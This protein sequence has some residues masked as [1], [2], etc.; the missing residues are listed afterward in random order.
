MERVLT[1][2][3]VFGFGG[4]KKFTGK[5]VGILSNQASVDVSLRTT[6]QVVEECLPGSVAALFGPQHGYRGED[7]DNMVETCHAEEP[8]LGVPV[9]SLYSDTRVPL[10]HML[11]NMEL[12][13]V[14][15]QDV[16]TRVYTFAS[17]V[18]NCLRA[19]A[20]HG[21]RVVVLDRPNPVGGD[22]TE[23]NVLDPAYFSFVG[24]ACIPMRHGLTLGELALLLNDECG[25]GCG[26]EVVPMQG[27][28]RGMLWQE[29][30][31][32]WLLPSTN[33][34]CPDTAA[35]YP[36]QVVWEGTNV[37]EGRGTCRP[38]EI[39]GAPFLDVSA[40]RKALDPSA[41]RGCYLQDYLFR[42]TFH[43]W[44]GELCRGFMLHVTD[45]DLY[46]PYYTSLCLLQA[47]LKV[48]PD[49]FQWRDP[50]YEY[51]YEKAP[52][53]LI[54]GDRKLSMDLQSGTSPAELRK[55]WFSDLAEFNERRA[56]Y[57]LYR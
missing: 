15:L 39:F 53:D 51:E 16:G 33:M 23:G 54:L 57:Y 24:P 30:G 37:S 47:V 38:F 8:L 48:H 2:L 42:P 34:P 13:L 25:I 12:L 28:H 3:D 50:P 6:A 20:V 21:V 32:R 56:R 11:E 27:W 1:G 7:Q 22:K 55:L 36:G 19:C 9:F 46:E 49:A 43:K 29:T 17:T 44:S 41:S 31:L 45:T 18:K 35:V 26:L 14:D 10:P 4:W 40:V 5:R 52:I